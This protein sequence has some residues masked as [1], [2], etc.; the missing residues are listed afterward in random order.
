M[1]RVS[2]IGGVF[3]E[4]LCVD[5]MRLRRLLQ[6]IWS[7]YHDRRSDKPVLLRYSLSL[8]HSLG[9][10]YLYHCT[11]SEAFLSLS[12]VFLSPT[13]SHLYLSTPCRN[14]VSQQVSSPSQHSLRRSACP[15][16]SLALPR[17]HYSAIQRSSFS[18]PGVISLGVHVRCSL[19]RGKIRLSFDERISSSKLLESF[20]LCT[21]SLILSLHLKCSPS[22]SAMPNCR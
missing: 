16:L 21:D 5:Q 4:R 22:S 10:K 1:W 2:E 14:V 12:L 20:S 17:C 18:P 3:G 15:L 7:Q 19:S 9:V 13:L 6:Y 8:S 11:L